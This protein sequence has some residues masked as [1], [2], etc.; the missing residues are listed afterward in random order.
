LDAPFVLDL[1]TRA[2]QWG[3]LE[4]AFGGGEPLLFRGFVDMVERLHQ[5]TPLGINFTTN[6]TLLTEDLL[7]RLRNVVGEMRVSAYSDNHYRRTLRMA[8]AMNVGVNWLVTPANVG[9]I[10][11]FVYDFLER[12][13]RNILLLGYK[14]QDPS[15]HLR[16]QHFALL[17]TAVS[18][19]Q[20]L[21]LRLD[22]CWYP[23]LADLPHLFGRA[24]CGAGNT[25]LVI[26]PDRAVQPCSFHHERTPFETF[27][28]LQA[29]YA[30]LR[31]RRPATTTPGCT[32]A[33]FTRVE[34]SSRSLGVWAW[35]ARAGNN[36]GD[37]TIV[38]R[39]REATDAS[40][41][42]EALRELARAHEAFLAS[43]E[44]N[45]WLID[46]Q[47][48]GGIPTPPLRKFGE[49]HGFDWT[50]DG[51]GLWWE[52]D[53][54]GAP[55]LTA[56]AVG[57]T[58][59]VYHP[60]CMGLPEEPFRK[61]F[62]AV[63]AIEFGYWQYDQPHVVARARGNNPAAIAAIREYL[64]LV[65]AAPYPSEVKTPPPWGT[66]GTDPR[67][68]DDEDRNATLDKKEFHL[69]QLG[70]RLTLVLSF[71]NTFAGALA[72]E[73]W[74]KGSGYSEV[75]I[76]IEQPLEGLS[77]SPG[78]PKEPVTNLFGGLLGG[79]RPLADRLASMTPAEVVET[80]FGFTYSVPNAMSQAIARI[81]L[82]ELAQLGRACWARRRH[83]G[84]DVTMQALRVI[85]HAGPAASDWIR[86]MWPILVA[87]GHPALGLAVQSMAAA[88][89]KDEAFGLASMWYK[90]VPGQEERKK[91]L[92][93]FGNLHHQGTIKL[94][95]QWWAAA[96]ANETTLGW[97]PVAAM[98]EMNWPD[99][100]R[101]L[102]SGRP[103]SLIALGVLEYYVQSGLPPGYI[104][105][106]RQVFR[107]EL[108]QC[109][110][111]DPAPRA[112][113]AVARLLDGEAK[114]TEP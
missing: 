112:S 48:H 27:E 51:E 113:S 65:G 108:Q 29:I 101:W 104:R 62:R 37:W 90:A 30:G 34:S 12:G 114:L 74:L 36:S 111:R 41:A 52:E 44:G 2:A 23:R 43:P 88:L 96:P 3:V 76:A 102:A 71:Q 67:L 100:S 58:V 5:T 59:V 25:F 80:L 42:A 68:L 87:Q 103:Q 81:P 18:R 54:A 69:E 46:N 7:A 92:Q 64:A 50:K 78:P 14:G 94:I 84:A 38:G 33:E 60:Y 31:C 93:S 24:D 16:E 82:T 22:V 63:G 85:Q 110:T 6:G 11:P 8:H 89:P 13:A 26:T 66:E 1:L 83:E 91:C 56:G 99:I 55:V 4:V 106:S 95:E 53:G 109:R 10:E 73:A 28:D 105:P 15:L 97:A 77:G 79:L 47:Y 49:A 70:D 40:K 75:T 32:R 61:F 86:E 21:P 72:L 20:H 107:Q 57:K 17:K 19:L 98:S 39:F 45:Q 35:Q 9:M